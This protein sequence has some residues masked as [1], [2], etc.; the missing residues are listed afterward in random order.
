MTARADSAHEA[1]ITIVPGRRATTLLHD[2]RSYRDLFFSLVRRDIRARYTQTVLGVGWAVI[3]PV[4]TMVVFSIF[5]GRLAD[6]PS[7]GVPYPVFSLAAV[8]PW[9]Y[10]ANS[11]GYATNSLISNQQVLSKVYFPRV[12][13]PASPIGGGLVDLAI[14][15]VILFCVM[16][17]FGYFPT[18]PLI[19]L[20]PVLIVLLAIVTTGVGLWLAALAIQFRDVRYTTPSLLQL[21]LFVTPI[22]YP[23]SVVPSDLRW[24]YSLNPM[25]GVIDGFR[26]VLL[27]TGP[28]QWSSLALSG[29][30]GVALVVSGARYFNKIERVFADIA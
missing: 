26:V 25:T 17:G 18:S 8:V 5:F 21:W 16:A 30:I 12:L 28:M 10:F 24:L 13:I 20:L 14:A 1:V 29:V 4:L 2:L 3:Q 7:S 22:I 15:L 19:V 27:D 11:V 6:V 9:T 23:L